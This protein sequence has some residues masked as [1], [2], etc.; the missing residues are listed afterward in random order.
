M[1]NEPKV[2]KHLHVMLPYYHYYYR[3][4]YFSKIFNGCLLHFN[5]AMVWMHP[6]TKGILIFKAYLSAFVCVSLTCVCRAAQYYDIYH[7]DIA[8]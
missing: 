7:Y 6:I 4:A 2:S 5:C 3:Q 8:C 1:G